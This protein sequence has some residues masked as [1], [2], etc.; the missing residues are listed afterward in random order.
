M[1]V[2]TLPDRQKIFK[3]EYIPSDI[4][5]VIRVQMLVEQN[6]RE[7]KSAEF[8]ANM[9]NLTVRVLIKIAK[10]HLGKSVYEL[11]QDRSYE[12]A[13]KLL[14][15]ST[16]SIKEI[17]YELGFCDPPYF[18]R[19]FKKLTGMLPMTYRKLHQVKD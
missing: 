8:Y 4:K 15:Y 12:E 14:K 1:N 17:T 18:L 16:I 11:I 5:S 3:E 6:F 7:E 19:C 10:A 9:L 13:I 2:I